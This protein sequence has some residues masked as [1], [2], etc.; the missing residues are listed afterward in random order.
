MKLG[1]TIY[2]IFILI[3]ISKYSYDHDFFTYVI[4]IYPFKGN[5]AYEIQRHQLT[6][7]IYVKLS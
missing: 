1:K 7:V 5:L 2:F 6:H 4:F 3:S